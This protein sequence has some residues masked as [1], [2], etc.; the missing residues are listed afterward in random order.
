MGP[1]ILSSIG[2][3]RG[4]PP[5]WFVFDMDETLTHVSPYYNLICTF[6]LNDFM[7]ALDRENLVRS[8]PEEIE[9][10]LEEAYKHFV[11]FC[12]KQ[13]ASKQPIGFLRP[14]MKELFEKIGM[15]KDRK[16]AAGCMIYSNNKTRRLLEFM[17]DLIHAVVGRDDL[18]CDVADY[19]DTRRPKKERQKTLTTIQ[20]ILLNG[21]CEA[22]VAASDIFF[23]DDMEHTDIRSKIGARYIRVYPYTYKT[24][25][26]KVLNLYFK[27]LRME[28]ILTKSA[29][30]KAFFRHL[31]GACVHKSIHEDDSVEEFRAYL[32][33][34]ILSKKGDARVPLT[35]EANN[36]LQPILSSLDRMLPKKNHIEIPILRNDSVDFGENPLS[37]IRVGGRRTTRRLKRVK[38][39]YSE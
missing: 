32:L 26:N 22:N 9:E 12:A 37:A 6:F 19:L 34:H 8:P 7:I 28:G 3:R 29:L 2:V 25:E 38:E 39:T 1:A 35:T 33:Q 27:S 4:M 21:P 14:G 24:D 5:Y 15:L 11:K 30:R 17:R 31:R 13:E 20:K 18:I 10:P 16:Q 36:S 23:F